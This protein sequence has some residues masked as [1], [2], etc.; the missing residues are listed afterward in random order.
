M[1]VAQLMEI[2]TIKFLTLKFLLNFQ[3]KFRQCVIDNEHTLLK[4]NFILQ[5]KKNQKTFE[6]PET[7]NWKF[8]CFLSDRAIFKCH[9]T[10]TNIKNGNKATKNFPKRHVEILNGF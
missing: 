2:E 5:M 7:Y 3:R 8:Y 10:V 4:F 6:R 1:S 9:A